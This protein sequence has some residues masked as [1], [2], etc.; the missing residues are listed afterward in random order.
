MQQQPPEQWISFKCPAEKN[1]LAALRRA[2]FRTSQWLHIP[3]AGGAGLISQDP[4]SSK[5]WPKNRKVNK[6]KIKVFK[7]WLL[8]KKKKEQSAQQFI[9]NVP[10]Y[11]KEFY[12]RYVFECMCICINEW[13]NTYQTV[14]CRH[15]WELTLRRMVWEELL[16]FDI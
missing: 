12:V 7:K 11:V 6:L 1:V 2:K 3:N 5:T 16:I 14:K 9:Q 10:A 4:T 15:L 13:K 8:L